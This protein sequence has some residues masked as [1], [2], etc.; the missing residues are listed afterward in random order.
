MTNRLFPSIFLAL[1]IVACQP[2][3]ASPT[4]VATRT[5]VPSRTPRPTQTASPTATPFPSLR[6]SGPYLL[7]SHDRKHFTIMDAD[8]GGR[9]QFQLPDNGYANW[10]LDQAVSPDGHW[11]AYFTGSTDEHYELALNLLNLDDLSTVQIATL[12]ASGFPENLRPV[13]IADSD[14]LGGCDELCQ[15]GLLESAF[16]RGIKALDW[17]PDSGFLA[18]A[19]QIDGPSSDVYLFSLQDKSTRRLVSDL[20]NIVWIEWSPSGKEILF[21]N[22]VPGETYTAR[23]LYVADPFEKDI[24]SPNSIFGGLFWREYGWISD[25]SYLVSSVAGGEI[26]RAHV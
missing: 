16:R 13:A 26:G 3:S 15:S 2:Q 12:I 21:V 22:S 1:M 8:G 19:A 18:F 9:R 25:N 10:D 6:T 17:S 7:F 11:L 5:I 14:L 4:P 24:Q 23:Y 20:E